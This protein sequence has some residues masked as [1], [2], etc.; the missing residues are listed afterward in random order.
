MRNVNVKSISY[1]KNLLIDSTATRLSCRLSQFFNPLLGRTQGRCWAAI[2]LSHRP[3]LSGRA[4]HEEVDGLGIGEHG[5]RFVLLRHTHTPQRRPYPICATRSGNFR[6]R[7]GGGLAGPRLCEDPLLE[8]R[9]VQVRMVPVG[10]FL[11]SLQ[12]ILSFHFFSKFTIQVP[13]LLCLKQARA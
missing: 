10:W 3:E 13:S 8:H 4:V 7:C 11:E 12:Q 9:F 6:H 5:R 1:L 2:R